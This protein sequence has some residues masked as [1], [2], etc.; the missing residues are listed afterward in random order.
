MEK[1][2]ITRKLLALALC[3]VVAVTF[4]P[5]FGDGVY[6]TDEEGQVNPGEEVTDEVVVVE[7]SDTEEPPTDVPD[8]DDVFTT[9]D[10]P[11]GVVEDEV[12]PA[13]DIQVDAAGV[14]DD[15]FEVSGPMSFDALEGAV[16]SA[17]AAN[18]SDVTL[19]CWYKSVPDGIV[20]FQIKTA[21]TSSYITKLIV[22]NTKYTISGRPTNTTV[23]VN[24]KEYGP[25]YCPIKVEYYKN[26]T[27]T[28]GVLLYVPVS[29]Y[30]T[31]SAGSISGVYH[32][33]LDYFYPADYRMTNSYPSGHGVFIDISPNGGASWP[34][35]YGPIGAVQ[36]KQ[37]TGLASNTNYTLRSYY[38]VAVYN[39]DDGKYYLAQGTDTGSVLNLGTYRTGVGSTVAV[40]SIKVKA[41]KVKKKKQRVYGYYTGLY[42]GSTKYYKYKLKIIIKLKKKPDTPYIWINGKTYKGNKKKYTVNLGS[43]TSYSKPKG[44]KY[45]VAIYKFFDG[46]YGGY[47]PMYTKVKKIK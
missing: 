9:N 2:S 19:T 10:N 3:L 23:D 35:T 33:Y 26:G 14:T 30:Y 36:S 34:S 43:F 31:P 15:T 29:I 41:Y 24:M 25:S 5:L 8:G 46:S 28:T 44:K 47:S 39:P 6:A 16:F 27:K 22:N 11:E 12:E 45:T 18:S 42:L 37:I 20:S 38:A 13:D 7:P 40:K 32:N 21:T 1:T 17:K 4:I